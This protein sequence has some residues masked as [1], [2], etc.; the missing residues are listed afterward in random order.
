MRETEAT[1]EVK[2]ISK[3]PN[4]ARGHRRAAGIRDAA[5]TQRA[6]RERALRARARP[7]EEERAAH[8]RPHPH[9]QPP[10]RGPAVWE[11][12]TDK[13]RRSSPA[14]KAAIPGLNLLNDR[15]LAVR[16]RTTD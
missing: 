11:A 16:T 8:P 15:D 2:R 14:P 10:S 13:P 1:K 6:L 4:H 5:M 12:A 7:E 9:F 3:T